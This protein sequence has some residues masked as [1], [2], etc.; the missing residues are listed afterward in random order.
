VKPEQV[1]DYYRSGYNFAKSTGMSANSLGNWLKWGF[2]PKDAQYKLAH[3]TGGSL[4][5]DLELNKLSCEELATRD[6][7]QKLVALMFRF[8]YKYSAS[9]HPSPAH[10][11]V[12]VLDECLIEARKQVS[13][14]E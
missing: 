10:I 12:S 4:T 7:K 2:V 11:M 14:H 6:F 1:K 9:L 5:V 13:V 8:A 3:I